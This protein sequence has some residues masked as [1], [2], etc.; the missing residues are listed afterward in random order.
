VAKAALELVVGGAQGGLGVDLAM[1]G[2]VGDGEQDVAQ[3]IG[4]ALLVRSSRR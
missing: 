4:Q 2:E 1:A 3:F